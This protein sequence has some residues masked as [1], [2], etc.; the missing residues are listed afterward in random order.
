MTLLV[1]YPS[2]KA[3]KEAIGTRLVFRET[4]VFSNQ[5][6]ENDR[7]PVAYRPSIWRHKDGGREFF[8]EVKIENGLIAKV[9]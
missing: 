2:K 8:A 3:L 1:C 7:F 4:S 5:Y 9:E 6:S